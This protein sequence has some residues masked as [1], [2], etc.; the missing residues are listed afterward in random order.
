MNTVAIVGDDVSET[1]V[2]QLLGSS[3]DCT[4]FSVPELS[5]EKLAQIVVDHDIC[6]IT[7]PYKSA[8]GGNLVIGRALYN[9]DMIAFWKAYKNI[10]QLVP[11]LAPICIVGTGCMA[12]QLIG[13]LTAKGYTNIIA[14]ARN[15]TYSQSVDLVINTVPKSPLLHP[16]LF[17]RYAIDL[18]YQKENSFLSDQLQKGAFCVNGAQMIRQNVLIALGYFNES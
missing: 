7:S 14:L 1:L 18:C 3:Y 6:F 9:T 13:L 2:P 15:S 10:I 8:L 12:N 17:G 5:A 4:K 11:K 16:A